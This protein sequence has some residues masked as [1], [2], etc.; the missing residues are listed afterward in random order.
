[1]TRTHPA[2]KLLLGDPQARTVFDDESC[3]ILELRESLL[4]SAVGGTRGSASMA[5]L[6]GGAPDGA[7][8]G[9]P[10]AS[11]TEPYQY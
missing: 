8:L 7:S 9:H 3:Q 10:S 1:M 2:G 11:S 5:S 6:L 4:L